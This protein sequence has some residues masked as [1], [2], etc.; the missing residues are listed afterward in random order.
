MAMAMTH[1]MDADEVKGIPWFKQPLKLHSARKYSCSLSPQQC[2]YQQGYWRFWYEL[3]HRYALPTVALFLAVIVLASIPYLLA[4]FVST[5]TTRF[6]LARKLRALARYASYR[7]F[8]I[9][10]LN[11]NSAPLGVLFLGAV[12]VVFFFSMVLGP[13]PYYWPNRKDP[14]LSF[15]NSPPLA[16]RSGWMALACLPFIIATSSKSN[17]IT[18][19]T[20]VSHERLQVFHRWISYACFVLAL[21]HTFPFIVYRTWKGDVQQ[22]W[23]DTI[24]YWTGS[25]ALIAQVIPPPPS[26]SS[27]C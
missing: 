22:Q 1:A 16:A 2:E 13:R 6:P 25:I 17:L 3:D 9:P 27:I 14:P 5:K 18:A 21:L 10:L 19:L 24:Y 20:G 4:P 15:G 12:G 11:W 8:R 7:S 23:D 26:I